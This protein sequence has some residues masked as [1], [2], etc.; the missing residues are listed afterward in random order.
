MEVSIG[1]ESEERRF[2]NFVRSGQKS[3]DVNHAT[4]SSTSIN[5]GVENVGA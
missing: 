1:R 3:D 2:E 4:L 5:D